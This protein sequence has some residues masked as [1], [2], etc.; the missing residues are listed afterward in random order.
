MLMCNADHQRDDVQSKTQ[1]GS[2]ACIKTE[3][4]HLKMFVHLKLACSE[5]LNGLPAVE[6]L[7]TGSQYCSGEMKLLLLSR[8]LVVCW[9]ACEA[10][11]RSR[12]KVLGWREEELEAWAALFIYTLF[13]ATR[14]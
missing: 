5:V 10:E 1:K 8:E 9:K 11:K 12:R 7:E 14:R 3:D 6:E 13:Q 2:K 4:L